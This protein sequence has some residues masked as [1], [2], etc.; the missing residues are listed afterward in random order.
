[1]LT[2]FVKRGNHLTRLGEA[3][4][5]SDLADADWIDLAEPTDEE[6]LLVE[7]LHQQHLPDA[8]ELEEIEASSRFSADSRGLRISSL[9]LRRLEGKVETVS[10]A[11]LI[12]P[13]RLISVHDPEVAALRLL[14]I[15]VPKQSGLLDPLH[16]VQLLFEIKVDDLADTLEEIHE[17]LDA[18][19]M[20]ML[21]RQGA[22]SAEVINRLTQLEHLNSKVRLCLLDTQRD[23]TFLLRHDVLDK[24]QR[25]AIERLQHDAES[26]LPHCSFLFEKVGFLMQALQG[27]ISIQQNQIIKFF[28]VIAVVFLPPTL[29]A[30]SYGMNFDIMPE[31]H[32]PYGY[33]M[34]LGLMVL[35]AVA[36]YLVF[37]K[38]GWL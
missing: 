10:V 37:R 25:R 26:L 38:K 2:A 15:R 17:E 21:G 34:A 28:S 33:P 7:Q 9:F 22:D 4:A 13:Q 3:T 14:R 24:A 31:L 20:T 27:A 8:D 1:M 12:S 35:S 11:L 6:R 18:L 16:L 5:A 23:C 19:G 32:W 29:V 36:P 30:S